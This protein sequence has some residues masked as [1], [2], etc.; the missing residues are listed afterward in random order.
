VNAEA[1]TISG[2]P[3]VGQTLTGTNGRWENDPT[4]F[5]YR[6]LRCAASGESCV[7]I[8][9]ATQRTY[10]LVGADEGRTM[11]FRVTAINA[12]GATSARS[13]PTD[14]VTAGQGGGQGPA[15]YGPAHDH[16]YASC[17]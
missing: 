16:G 1:P 4:A 12:D 14:V 9:I 11:R 6:W 3:R 10:R 8:P 2:T 5:Q 15:Q 17:G 7:G 13:E